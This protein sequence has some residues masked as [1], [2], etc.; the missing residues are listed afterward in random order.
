MRREGGRAGERC[1]TDKKVMGERVGWRGK[2]DGARRVREKGGGEKSGE[3]IEGNMKGIRGRERARG[4]K[5][6]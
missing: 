2:K 3:N 5:L 6:A 4:S 1:T